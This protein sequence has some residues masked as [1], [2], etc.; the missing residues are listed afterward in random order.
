MQGGATALVLHGGEVLSR[1][2]ALDLVVAARQ[3]GV[4]H[5]CVWTSGT[6]L[7]RP[8]VAS[9]LRHA[10]VTQVVL[11]L[12]GD[13]ASGHDHVAAM[14][15][16]FQR[17]LAALQACRAAKLETVVLAPV[18]R[19]TLRGLPALVQK[20][21]PA[22]VTGMYLW[23]PPGPDRE[24]HPLLAP[25]QLAAP[26]VQAAARLLT[27]AQRDC[28]IE[29]LPPCLLGDHA[30]R[31]VQRTLAVDARVPQ[32]LPLPAAAPD[33]APRDAQHGPPCT[34]CTWRP[35]CPGL[36][37]YRAT[38]HGWATMSARSDPPARA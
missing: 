15:G 34:S 31:L 24:T 23:A 28:Q 37:S 33:A 4:Q 6:L 27:T 22:G 1:P 13:T 32:P 2:E 3:R 21:V 30:S 29:G 9:A 26:Y 19:P 10:G 17:I 11:P 36:A 18:L 14:D 8:R 16:H 20:A 7:A 35:V 38:A 12:W 5:L 25:L